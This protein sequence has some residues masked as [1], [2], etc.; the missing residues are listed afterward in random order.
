[1]KPVDQ[2][3]FG[4]PNGNCYAACV[5]SVLE[6]ELRKVPNF[7]R[8]HGSEKWFLEFARWLHRR[9][10]APV[11]I[12]PTD[13]RIWR[14]N[15]FGIAG[16]TCRTSQESRRGLAHACVYYGGELAHDPNPER[17]GLLE[18]EELTFLVP[19]EVVHADQG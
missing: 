16:G 11:P 12:V 17:S 7:C 3:I 1:M 10:Y 13:E 4:A 9:G 6:I 8:D 18:V 5:A 14:P 15:L 2:T 19:G